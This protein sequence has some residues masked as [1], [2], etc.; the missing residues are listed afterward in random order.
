MIA[1]YHNLQR[2]PSVFRSLTG[3]RVAEFDQLMKDVTPLYADAER[4]RHT[5]TREGHPRQ[6]AVG[7]GPHFS[8]WVRDQLLL[9]V[10]WLRQYPTNE[11]AGFLFG[12]SDSTVSRLVSR[13][14]PLLAKAGKD[15]MRMPDPGRKHRRTLD[16][17]LSEIPELGVVIDTFEQPVQRPKPP[18]PKSRDGGKR[19]AEA[20]RWYSGKK[21]RHTVKS[22]VGVDR[23]SGEIVDVGESVP[24]PTNDLIL[25]KQSK[26]LERLPPGV[27]GEGD[28]AY[29]GIASL[30][31]QKLG[32][33]PRRKP[34]GADK[35]RPRGHDKERPPQDIAYN[36]AFAHSRIVVEHTIL[37]MRRYQCLWQTDRHHRRGHTER[38]AAVAGLV[39]R[40]IRHRLPYLVN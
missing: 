39:N 28:L 7:A 27:S 24:G 9:A 31:P 33:T 32:F 34:R 22:Q 5:F 18:K 17:L 23:N 4:A 38:V 29:V 6:R 11:V 14:V 30:H 20:D 21:K 16:D 36:T 15:G 1:R 8:L 37:R 10:V 13:V 35:H 12:V 3:L 25:L 40:Q 19:E 2:Y 26:L